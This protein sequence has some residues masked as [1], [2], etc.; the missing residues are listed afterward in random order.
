MNKNLLPI[1]SLLLAILVLP[2]CEWSCCDKKGPHSHTAI[3][4]M[5]GVEADDTNIMNSDAEV[6]ISIGGV[7]SVRSDEFEMDLNKMLDSRPDLKRII[8]TMMPGQFE[9]NVAEGLTHQ[10]IVEKYIEDKGIDKTAAYQEEMQE[11]IKAIKRLTSTKFFANTF[12][13]NISNE[14]IE[15][16]YNENKKEM[17]NLI[18]SQG[19]VQVIG[20]PFD[21]KESAQLFSDAV[22]STNGDI[23]VVAQQ[24]NSSDKLRDFKLVNEASFD[25][26][27]AIRELVLSTSVFPTV[28]M[29]E[30]NNEY[31]VL[32]MPY[33]EEA[34][35][36]PLDDKIKD[37][38]RQYLEKEKKEE[39]FEAEINKLKEEYNV[40]INEAYFDGYKNSNSNEDSMLNMFDNF[41]EDID[42]ESLD[43][44]IDQGVA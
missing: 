16:F 20:V 28:E 26:D 24:M 35:Y 19:G 2:S 27:P 30:I 10:L 6:V 38:I 1:L 18:I 33:K 40:V 29:I 43:M 41:A 23:K 21:T 22:S 9:R 42:D 5:E 32:S 34:K 3:E 17:H 15:R 37:S 8:A 13:V 39:L 7:P 44:D 31:W 12:D 25:V 36:R 4:K 14:D 11:G